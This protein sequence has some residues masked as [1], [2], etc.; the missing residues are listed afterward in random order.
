MKEHAAVFRL[1]RAAALGALLAAP[2]A[3]Q[4][5]PV[6]RRQVVVHVETEPGTVHEWKYVVG[7]KG[8]PVVLRTLIVDRGYLGIELLDLTPE[9]RRHFGAPED[10]GAM[11]SLIEAGSPAA[12]AGVQLADV[13]V[14]IDGERVRSARQAAAA[15][16]AG[17][18]GDA[19]TLRLVRDGTVRTLTATLA[20]RPRRQLD[21]GGLMRPAGGAQPREVEAVVLDAGTVDEALMTL[22][23][24]LESPEWEG[25]LLQM[26]EQRRGLEGR[27]RELEERLRQLEKQLAEL[28]R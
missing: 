20:Q 5:R 27:I 11:V 23:R 15:L 2:L 8:E 4:D 25:R 22:R 21:L 12:A 26:S 3:A 16:G 28:P 1:T 9:L 19:A 24:R 14:A 13:L 17:K 18:E 6:E 10:A 7:E